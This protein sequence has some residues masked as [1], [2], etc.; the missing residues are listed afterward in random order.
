MKTTAQ[1]LPTVATCASCVHWHR[2]K[3]VL[4]ERTGHCHLLPPVPIMAPNGL[5]HVLPITSHDYGC[6][7][8]KPT[9]EGRSD[10]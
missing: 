9:E 7:S 5:C 3:S 10:Q 1:A 2:R 8:F 4:A 6:G